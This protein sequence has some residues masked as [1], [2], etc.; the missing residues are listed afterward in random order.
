MRR[1][2]K[3]FNLLRVLLVTL[4]AVLGSAPFLVF[5]WWLASEDRQ[6]QRLLLLAAV[7]VPVFA[8]EAWA[9]IRGIRRWNHGRRKRKLF[10][11]AQAPTVA[12]SS[13]KHH[14]RSAESR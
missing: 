6:L 12:M 10:S 7:F 9:I 8:L 4:A 5:F 11:Q 1:D 13:L 3:D 14:R 2:G